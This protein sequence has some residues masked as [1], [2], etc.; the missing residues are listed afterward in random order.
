MSSFESEG[1]PSRA[2]AARVG[3]ELREARLS[4]GWELDALAA[5]LRIRPAYLDAIEAGRISDLPGNAYVLGFLRTYASAL[6]LDADEMTRRFRAEVA[7]VNTKTELTFPAPVPERGVP[8]GAVIL[9]GLVVAI[10]AYVGWY[11][12]A[13]HAPAGGGA[14]PVAAVP[15][16]LARLAEPTALAPK[17]IANPAPSIEHHSAATAGAALPAAPA[18]VSA[19]ASPASTNLASQNVAASPAQGSPSATPGTSQ[20]AASHAPLHKPPMPA[21]LAAVSA[22]AP[23]AQ[24]APAQPLRGTIVVRATSESWVEVRDATGGVVFTKLMQ[25]GETWTAPRKSGLTLTTGNAG[26]TELLIDG[27]PAPSLG[28]PGEV[29]RDQPLDAELIKAGALPAQI[30]AAAA[31]GS[32]G[33]STSTRSSQ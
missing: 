22:L 32:D 2:H 31:P 11:R 17:S 28:S 15:P 4:Y 29:E 25:P 30:A 21:A 14:A 10:G 26:G 13:E 19:A 33:T 7:E 16:R 23:S 5:S 18:T 8:A 9:L 20:G 12:L 1:A 6:G 27:T 3:A 24:A